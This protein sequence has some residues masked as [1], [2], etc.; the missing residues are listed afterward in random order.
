MLF[1][2]SLGHHMILNSLV[3]R[4]SPPPTIISTCR[5]GDSLGVVPC[6]LLFAAS[7]ASLAFEKRA[8]PPFPALP[9]NLVVKNREMR[10]T[11]GFWDFWIM[12]SGLLQWNASLKSYLQVTFWE[13]FTTN[14]KLIS[15]LHNHPCLPLL[16][17]V[18]KIINYITK[19]TLIKGISVNVFHN[20]H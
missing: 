7:I 15:H 5:I 18:V 20:S 17:S 11:P 3:D 4:P 14:Q 10:K 13:K 8:F 6:A 19:C 16:F 2:D 12:L 9:R 1:E